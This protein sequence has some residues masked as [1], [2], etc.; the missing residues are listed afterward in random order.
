MHRRADRVRPL[1]AL[2]LDRRP[3]RPRQRR[4][5][6]PLAVVVV[7][8]RYD[9]GP[10]MLSARRMLASDYFS[11]ADLVV[12]RRR[13]PVRPHVR[14]VS[15]RRPG[16]ATLPARYQARI[17]THASNARTPCS[18]R[19]RYPELVV[20][21]VVGTAAPAIPREFHPRSHLC[22]GR[23]RPTDMTGQTPMPGLDAG[24]HAEHS[25]TASR[26][27]S[28]DTLAAPALPAIECL[29]ANPRG[30]RPPAG[31]PAS[32]GRA[33]QRIRQL[34]PAALTAIALERPHVSMSPE[35]DRAE[36]DRTAAFGSPCRPCPD[37]GRRSPA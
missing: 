16:R 1:T 28:T 32:A 5:A 35:G 17:A 6:L 34:E 25:T 30:P 24:R 14:R 23:E 10:A 22:A 37:R 3:S 11:C 2:V 12:R 31:E 15:S 13:S 36:K 29:H 21:Q 4:D 26:G 18:G 33:E 8:L 19:P 27:L 7:A 9:R 20:E